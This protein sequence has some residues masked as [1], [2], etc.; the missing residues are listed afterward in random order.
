MERL[1]DIKEKPEFRK[2]NKDGNS[3]FDIKMAASTI[4]SEWKSLSSSER[5]HFDKLYEKHVTQYQK[6]LEAWKESLTPDDIQRQNQ[7]FAYQRKIGKKTVPRNIPVPKQLKR[8]LSAFFLFTQHL[9]ETSNTSMP[10]TEFARHA[11]AKWKA[12]S[13]TE[14]EQFEKSA[15]ASKEEYQRRV[16]EFKATF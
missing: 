13:A 2:A 12:M 9:R 6:D 14:K 16:E 5:D 7:F 10:V 15:R 11:G 3:V 1:K 8:P 4:G